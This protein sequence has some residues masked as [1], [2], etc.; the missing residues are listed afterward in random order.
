MP[1]TAPSVRV[2]LDASAGNGTLKG[3]GLSGTAKGR[4]DAGPELLA[5]CPPGAIPKKGP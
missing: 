3:H 5:G 2:R 1:D 4:I